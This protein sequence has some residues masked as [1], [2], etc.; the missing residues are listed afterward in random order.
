MKTLLEVLFS[1]TVLIMSALTFSLPVM[2]L[3]DWLMP[4][5]FGL[6]EISWMQAFGLVLLS[7]FL[8]RDSSSSSKDK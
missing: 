7:G 3:W 4:D 2:L 5:I 1:L 8:F 6:G